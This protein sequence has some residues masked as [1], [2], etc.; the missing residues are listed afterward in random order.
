MDDADNI[1]AEEAK[2]LT[3]ATSI[4]LYDVAALLRSLVASLFQRILI[5]RVFR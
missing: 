5:G 2:L 3:S 4:G 1:L